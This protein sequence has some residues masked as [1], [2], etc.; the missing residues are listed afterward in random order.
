MNKVR[1][2]SGGLYV[3]LTPP[4]AGGV[5][6][7]DSDIRGFNMFVF[8]IGRWSSGYTLL[9]SERLVGQKMLKNQPEITVFK[10]SELNCY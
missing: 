4:L 2:S 8:K 10:S 7:K 6:C 1:I 3:S 9:E 5:M